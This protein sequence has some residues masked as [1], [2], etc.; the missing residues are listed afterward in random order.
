MHHA[1]T[2]IN[3]HRTQASVTS[4]L[5]G[6]LSAHMEQG[7]GDIGYHLAV[8]YVGRVWE[9]R[10]LSYEG[11]HV[12]SEN[13]ANIGVLLLGNFERQRPSLAQLSAMEDLVRI[14]RHHFR[15]SARRVYGHRD[16]GSSLCPG[17]HPY[18]Y[19]RSMRAG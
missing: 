2:G 3:R 11:A 1:G 19:V 14:L 16:L 5:T 10:S 6:I 18:P 8:D 7:Y 13:E 17:A 15:I 12:L 4:D 9:G